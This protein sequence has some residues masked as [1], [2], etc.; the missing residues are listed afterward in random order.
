MTDYYLKQFDNAGIIS[1]EIFISNTSLLYDEDCNVVRD[2]AGNFYYC[3]NNRL[4][5]IT[6]QGVKTEIL[7]GY[8]DWK[9]SHIALNKDATE[10][11]VLGWGIT[12]LAYGIKVW[13]VPT[14]TLSFTWAN[15]IWNNGGGWTNCY[16][17][18][19]K[20]IVDKNNY[21]WV[22]F[23]NH[24]KNNITD[25]V[26]TTDDSIYW[27][28]DG[29]TPSS[30]GAANQACGCVDKNGI[31][32][33]GLTNNN[34]THPLRYS[35]FN[36]IEN[37]SYQAAIMGTSTYRYVVDSTIDKDNILIFLHNN[38]W[39]TTN[40]CKITL[41]NIND[42]DNPF[43]I[44][45]EGLTQ[46][47]LTYGGSNLTSC[48]NLHTNLAG[49]IFFSNTSGSN[50]H[51]FK[52]EVDR[53]DPENPILGEPSI[54]IQDKYSGTTGNDPYGVNHLLINSWSGG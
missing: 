38:K 34:L 6:S 40:A 11:A 22:E 48:F 2:G 42:K 35:V 4:G 33:Y 44:T 28:S 14:D 16:K 3:H 41:V 24:Y 53:S 10:L 51:T 45:D 21:I 19:K 9:F 52:I 20:I 26:I 7:L 8:G 29:G 30:Y 27:A 12:G 25:I 17:L 32:W 49:D 39:D 46:K 5:R 23:T 50:L 1:E 37:V 15:D 43:I 36:G 54:F 31:H 18:T 13:R 47:L